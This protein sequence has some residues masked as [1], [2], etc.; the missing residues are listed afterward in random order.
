VRGRTSVHKHLQQII[1]P[2]SVLTTTWCDRLAHIANKRC[3]SADLPDGDNLHCGWGEIPVVN[4]LRQ[5]LHSVCSAARIDNITQILQWSS[6]LVSSIHQNSVFNKRFTLDSR[7]VSLSCVRDE[8]TQGAVY[9]V[10]LICCRLSFSFR[11]IYAIFLFHW[12]T[13]LK[14]WSVS[15]PMISTKQEVSV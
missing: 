14:R 5:L 7:L 8:T 6:G 15:V 12:L 1:T 13:L 9:W 10:S 4:S 2:S 11:Q 3:C